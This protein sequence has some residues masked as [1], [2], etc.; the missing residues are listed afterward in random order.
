VP[1]R[2]P[3]FAWSA[4]AASVPSTTR[5]TFGRAGFHCLTFGPG[6]WQQ[7][8]GRERARVDRRAEGPGPGFSAVGER[9]ASWFRAVGGGAEPGAPT[10]SGAAEDEL[11]IL[12][13]RHPD[14]RARRRPP[15]TADTGSDRPFGRAR[16]L[17]PSRTARREPVPATGAA[18]TCRRSTPRRRYRR[19][20]GE[21]AR[22]RRRALPPR[23]RSAPVPAERDRNPPELHR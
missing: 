13:A 4:S 3:G 2:R 21:Q 9:D 22:R 19:Q 18:G 7:L 17:P 16:N 20:P 12:G 1:A 11:T 15:A 8:A 14:Q 6:A 5:S 23:A 10:R